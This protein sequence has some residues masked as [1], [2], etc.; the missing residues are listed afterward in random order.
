MSLG[1]VWHNC[2]FLFYIC[3][4]LLWTEDVS[5]TR[6]CL[7]NLV[8][9]KYL[10]SYNSIFHYVRFYNCSNYLSQFTIQHGT[11]SQSFFIFKIKTNFFIKILILFTKSHLYTLI[12]K[13]K[14]KNTICRWRNCCVKRA[15]FTCY[16]R[17]L[18][19]AWHNDVI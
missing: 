2:K 16:G 12:C 10:K 19:W 14:I 15:T 11:T 3:D 5:E 18:Y 1:Q 6:I 4:M 7:K 9:L 17:Q 8:F 13:S